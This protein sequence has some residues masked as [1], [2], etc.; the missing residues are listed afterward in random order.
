MNLRPLLALLIPL[1]AMAGDERVA[2]TCDNGS[3]IDISFSTPADGRPQATLHFADEALVLPQ[4]LAASGTAYRKDSVLLHTQGDEAYFEDGKGNVRRCRQGEAPQAAAS[5]LIDLAG[6]VSFTPRQPLPA[7]AVL[8]LRVQD[9][10]RRGTLTLLE[11]RIRLNGH[12]GPI[13]FEMTVDRDLLG[14][15]SKPYVRARIEHKGKRLFQEDGLYPALNSN[16]QAAT[17]DIH[18]KTVKK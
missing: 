8:I 10:S 4:V 1:C 14:K 7:A 2:Y 12:P 11:Q 9:T 13:P 5:S 15:H 3:R 16:G 17:L 6:Q 18:L